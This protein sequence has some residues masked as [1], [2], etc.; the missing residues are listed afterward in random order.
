LVNK[1]FNDT[2]KNIVLEDMLDVAL[3]T[4]IETKDEYSNSGKNINPAC[5]IQI[6]NVIKG[7]EDQSLALEKIKKKIESKNLT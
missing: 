5:L 6:K 2:H 3:E 1:G 4:F 7:D